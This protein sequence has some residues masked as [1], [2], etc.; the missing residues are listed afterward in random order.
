MATLPQ[1]GEVWWVDLGLAAKIRPCLVISI[2]ADEVNDRV[3]TTV[4]PHTTSVRGSRFEVHSNV[5]FLKS[6]AFDVQNLLTIPTVKLS[7]KIGGL[8][9]EQMHALENIVQVWLGLSIRT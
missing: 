4:I 9:P 1:R 7:R 6:G 2:P 5:H 3:L 8:T